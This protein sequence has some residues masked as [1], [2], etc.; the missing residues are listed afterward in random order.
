MLLNMTIHFNPY[1]DEGAYVDLASR[2]GMLFGEKVVGPLGLLSELEERLGISGVQVSGVERIVLYVKAMRQALETY[3]DLFFRKSFANDEIGTARTLL[4]WRDAAI[5]AGWKAYPSQPSPKFM[6]LAVVES[7]FDAPGTADRWRFLKDHL[8]CLTTLPFDV[9]IIVHCSAESVEPY[10]K[11]ILDAVSRLGRTLEYAPVEKPSAVPG[12]DLRKVQEELLYPA[13]QIQPG[14]RIPLAG[15]GT[16]R[17]VHFTD[18]SD[19][20]QWA[21]ATLPAK[22]GALLVN[23]VN[24]AVSDILF[25]FSEPTVASSVEVDSTAAQLFRL[26]LSLFRAPV[27]VNN[28]LAYLR[29]PVNP[30]SAVYVRKETREGEVYY[31]SLNKELA[32]SLIDTGGLS[33][34]QKIIDSAEYDHDGNPARAGTKDALLGRLYMWDK[35][36]GVTVRKGDL[37]AYLDNLCS[38]S[39]GFPVLLGDPS[40]ALM[41]DL[42]EAFRL[43]MENEP[44][45][46]PLSKLLNW[47]D[48]LSLHSSITVHQAQAGSVPTVRNIR[49]LF[50]GP[51]DLVWL[52]CVGIDPIP[53]DY[54]YLSPSERRFFT[55]GFLPKETAA[56]QAH[57]AIIEAVARISGS[58]TLVTYDTDHGSL[59]TEHPVITELTTRFD[60][61]K[62]EGSIPSDLVKTGKIVGE[63][64]F[65]D[66]YQIDPALLEGRKRA[67]ESYSSLSELFQSP[68][69]YVL[70]YILKYGSNGE[71]TIINVD[72][73]KGTVAHKYIEDLI[74]D[75]GKD[76]TVMRSI[77]ETDYEDRILATAQNVGVV[78]LSDE[79]RLEFAKFKTVFRKSVLCF[80]D[81]VESNG[82]SIFGTEYEVKTELPVI[83][84]FY[85]KVDL[86]L[87]N[88][89]GDFV[90]ADFKWSESS[91]Y[92]H[93]LEGERILQLALYRAAVEKALGVKVLTTGYFI[94]PKYSFYTV[95]DVGL[96]SHENVEVIGLE[97]YHDVFD[98]ACNSYRYRMEQLKSGIIEEGEGAERCDLQY[99]IDTE[100][101]NLYPLEGD[102][103]NQAVKAYNHWGK[104]IILKGGLV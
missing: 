41:G 10:I 39:A 21:A 94:L 51:W 81:F 52:D 97:S 102:Y 44:E 17:I 30:V 15:D 53:Y 98:Q 104:N 82:F 6:G 63:I 42:T 33:E 65:K 47:S 8:E 49:C 31:R 60:I 90:I 9:R 54:D 59:S 29:L 93:A 70:D 78:M 5:L 36:T 26:G 73:V 50:D 101:Y 55:G 87:K 84:N 86:L 83:G 48:G 13:G 25:S 1:Y 92:V 45:E 23:E 75:C 3:P 32:D 4:R 18:I 72:A 64:P 27:D 58:L 37:L 11:S 19:A 40:W 20:Q 28:L 62:E 56:A 66:V 88:A 7:H 16:V 12:T 85:A 95:H 76:V 22:K 67:T 79:N 24:N 89:D 103:D 2:G 77:H 69:D 14:V 43:L 46:I 91:Y 74:N 99:E 96:T 71:A 38:W 100:E 80:L 61:P 35:S 68:F 57:N 34:W